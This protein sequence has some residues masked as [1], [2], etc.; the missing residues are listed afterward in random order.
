MS[1]LLFLFIGYPIS[2]GKPLVHHG[3]AITT[4]RCYAIGNTIQFLK[5]LKNNKRINGI[6]LVQQTVTR[7]NDLQFPMGYLLLVT[8]VL[9]LIFLFKILNK[10]TV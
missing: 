4:S 9:Q 3:T 8:V 5:C 1:P 10:E 6:Q 2:S 7:V